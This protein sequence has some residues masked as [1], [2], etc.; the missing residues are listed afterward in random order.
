MVTVVRL[1]KAYASEDGRV[2]AVAGVTFDVAEGELLA[3]LG[4]S[5]CGKTTTLR[6]LAG[7]EQPDAG[8]IRIAGRTVCDA[9]RGIHQPPYEREIG[10]V[11]QSYAI[12]PHLDV[13]ENVAYPLRVSRQRVAAREISDRVTAT[14]AQVGLGGLAR[15][16]ASA[17]SGGQQ[18]RVALARAIVRRPRLLLLDE[19]LSNL[20]VR[21]RE[22]MQHELV[23]L[24][25]RVGVTTVHVTHDQGE[26]LAMADRVAVMMDGR[27]TQI[28]DPETLYEHPASAAIA[29]FLGAAPPIPATLVEHGENGTATL[30]LSNGA[31][32]LVARCPD[33]CRVGERLA[34][35]IRSEHASV[36]PARPERDANVLAGTVERVT[37]KGAGRECTVRI[38][39]VDVRA[40]LSRDLALR[41]GDRA[42]LDVDPARVLVFKATGS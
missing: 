10:M 26:A 19:P 14:L 31:G 21:L 25:R 3:L 1:A 32:R 24:V 20:D 18:Q 4:P 11:F 33:D 8:E 34:V 17:L 36:L 6:C 16:S 28:A 13:F 40:T 12:W 41:P 37:V 27:L 39:G 5:G 30:A 7:L 35:N 29:T 38:D 22:Q 42:W 9:A 15:R 2:G 23:D